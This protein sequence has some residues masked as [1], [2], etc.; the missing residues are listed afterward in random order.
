M[1]S[2]RTLLARQIVG[3]TSS[4]FTRIH[5]QLQPTVSNS[6]NVLIMPITAT[7]AACNQIADTPIVLVARPTM[8][9]GRASPQATAGCNP[10][11]IQSKPND[12]HQHHTTA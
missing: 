7:M 1:P 5:D 12:D 6:K 11:L 8:Q 10:P 4:D 3:P 9:L 2:Y